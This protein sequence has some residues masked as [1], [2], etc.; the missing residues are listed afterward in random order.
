VSSDVF[1]NTRI[2]LTLLA[3]NFL[4]WF[5]DWIGNEEFEKIPEIA[6]SYGSIFLKSFE[7]CVYSFEG[8]DDEFLEVSLPNECEIISNESLNISKGVLRLT[9]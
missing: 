8:G 7:E 9:K 4:T 2:W 3:K 1:T 6:K 5:E